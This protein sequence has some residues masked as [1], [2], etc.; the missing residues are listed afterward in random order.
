MTKQDY[1]NGKQKYNDFCGKVISQTLTKIQKN[2]DN[3]D[4]DFESYCINQVEETFESMLL[5]SLNFI[6]DVYK[7]DTDWIEI[8]ENVV[9]ELTFSKDGKNF[10]NR[11]YEHYSDYLNNHDEN[12]F[13]NAINKILNT[14]SRYIFNHA[15]AQEVGPQAIKCEI[16]G[17]NACDECLDHLGG[18]RINPALLTDIPPYHP[19]CECNIVYYLPVSNSEESE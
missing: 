15:L 14:E 16:I 18:G 8:S 2:F 12:M 4:I 19:N 13:L 9:L 17:D 5:H 11:I 6:T 7:I 10:K 3:E 1:L